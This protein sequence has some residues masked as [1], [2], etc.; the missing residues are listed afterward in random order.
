MPVSVEEKEGLQT[1][2]RAQDSAEEQQEL[3]EGKRR[4]GGE[5]RKRRRSEMGEE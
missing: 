5:G 3:P 1:A 4:A 2:G